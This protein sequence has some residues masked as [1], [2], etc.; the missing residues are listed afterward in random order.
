MQIQTLVS[1]LESFKENILLINTVSLIGPGENTQIKN[2]L[3]PPPPQTPYLQLLISKPKVLSAK[4][5][6]QC[7]Q[8]KQPVMGDQYN[9]SCWFHF[10]SRDKKRLHWLYIHFSP[11]SDKS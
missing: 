1:E 6:Q 2:S 11:L 10:K 5:R 8:G 4:Q 9:T 7:M 3:I